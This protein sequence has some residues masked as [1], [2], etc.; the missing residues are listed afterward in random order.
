MIEVVDGNAH[1]K[2][3]IMSGS[4]LIHK[5]DAPADD[6]TVT[7]RWT[8][9]DPMRVDPSVPGAEFAVLAGN[10]VLAAFW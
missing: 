5:S 9:R 10:S 3:P 6:F 8:A 4:V 1:W 2:T 7:L